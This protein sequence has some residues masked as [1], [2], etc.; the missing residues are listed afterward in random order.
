MSQAPQE[1]TIVPAREGDVV[2]ILEFVRKLAEYERLSA[3]V[4][5]NEGTLR[6]SL[7]GARPAAEVVFALW[8]SE[9]VGFAVFFPN[10]STFMGRPGLYLEDLFVLTEFRGRGVGKALLC[11]LARL[12][13]QRK[14]ARLEWAVLDWNQQAL[15]FYRRLGATPM[16][17]WTVFRLT[18]TALDKLADVAFRIPS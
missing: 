1:I 9:P 2:L 18:G 6:E 17:D 11:H 5:A 8:G 7:F 14:Y 10:F 15:D 13:K 16:H 3:E 12:A 4:I